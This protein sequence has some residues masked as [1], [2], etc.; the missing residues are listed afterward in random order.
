MIYSSRWRFKWYVRT[1]E[2]V[3]RILR[4]FRLLERRFI[5]NLVDRHNT[6][7]L[8]K[9]RLN[10]PRSI[11]LILPRCVKKPGCRIAHSGEMAACRECNSC[12]LGE[13]ARMT[14]S[15][16]VRSLVAFRSHIAFAM[17][18]EEKPDL[19]IATACDDR[20]IKALR[21]VPEI[22]SLLA[23]LR[24]SERK[25]IDCTFDVGWF[26]RQLRTATGMSPDPRTSLPAALQAGTAAECPVPPASSI[27][28]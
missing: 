16:G 24:E 22:P 1:V 8:G 28:S 12:I 18:R 11:L 9:L 21:S 15:Y 10:P 3:R 23:P 5:R 20:M 2:A 19:I 6:R 4:P 17:A 14:E 27:R 25:C 26:E 7:V 13:M